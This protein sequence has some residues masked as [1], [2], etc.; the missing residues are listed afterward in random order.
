MGRVGGI[1]T[2]KV[3][4]QTFS[5]KGNFTYDIGENLRKAVVGHDRV[6]GYNEL[7]KQAFIAGEITDSADSPPPNRRAA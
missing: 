4:G 1:I 2:L 5:A 3:N 6:H 7:P